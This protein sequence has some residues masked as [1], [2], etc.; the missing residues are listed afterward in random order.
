MFFK[1]ILHNWSDENCA[2]ILQ[3]IR[4][5][6]KKESKLLVIEALVTEKR[7]EMCFGRM[8]D[9]HMMTTAGGK[10]RTFKEYETLLVENGWKV[11]GERIPFFGDI[12]AME[13][14]ILD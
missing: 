9:V 6:A 12:Y 4:K 3:N 1:W 5:C 2:K 8:M 11:V 14:A 7:N 13:A 10:D